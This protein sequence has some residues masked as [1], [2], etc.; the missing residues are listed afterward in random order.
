MQDPHQVRVVTTAGE[1]RLPRRRVL[2]LTAAAA[3]VAGVSAAGGRSTASAAP[4]AGEGF[5]A[6][7]FTDPRPD[8]RPTVLWFWNGTVTTDLVAAQLADLR[9]QGVFEVL[10]FPFD[11]SALRPRFFTEDWFTLIEFTLREAQRHG[12]HLWLFNDDFFPSGRGGGFV[13]NGGKVGD[14]VY[15]P[16]PDLG[17]KGVGRETVVVTGAGPVPLVSRGLSVSDGR[18]LVDASARNGITL[19]RAG[20]DWQ[21][22]AVVAEVRVDRGTAGLV[23]RARDE[24]NG[25]LA[26][27]R[28]DGAVDVWRQVDGAFT[29]VRGGVPVEGFDPAVDH[30]LEVEV[31]GDRIVPSVDGV[32]QPAVVDGTYAT[33]RVGVRAVADQRSSWDGLTVVDAAGRTLFAD[34]FDSPAALDAFALPAAVPPV[35][36]T[37]RPEG[38]A[39]VASVIDLTDLAR[40]AGVWNAPAGRWRVDLFT[41][42]PLGG[43]AGHTYL[44]LLDDEA[45][46]LF[47]DVVPGEYLRRF[48]WAVGGVLRGFADDEPFLASADAHFAAV[49]WSRSLDAELSRSGVTPGIALAA[50]HDE[51]GPDG[52]RLRGVFWR[53]VSDRFASAYHRRQGEWM[54]GHGLRF[55]SNPL[56]DEYGPG[57]QVRSSG[58]LNTTNQW[59]QVPGTDLIFDHFQRGHHRTLS[60]WPASTAHQLGLE[61]VYL[62]AMGGAGWQVT[63]A[64]TREVVGAFAV[65][66]V[67][68]TLLHARFTDSDQ[69]VYPPP[70]Q[71][72]N[73]WWDV[74]APLNDWIGRL[75]EA[76]R[77]PAMA[78][79]ALVQ[80]QRAVETFQDTATLAP[81]DEAFTGAAHALEDVQVDFDFVDEGALDADPALVAHARPSGSALAL[82]K[83][84]YRVVV[85]PWTPVLALGAVS[86]LT[87]FVRGG[88]TLVV[89]GELPTRE[90][91]GRHADLR[92]ALDALFTGPRKAIRA[93]DPMA[94]AAAVVAAGAAAVSLSPPM[95]DVRVL[96]LERGRERAF[97]LMNERDAAVDVTATFPA[98]GVPEVWDPDSGTATTAGVWRSAPFTGEPDGGTAV[99]LRLEPKATLL[100]VFRVGREPAHAVSATAPVE[101]VRVDGGKVR[102]TVRVTAPGPVTVVATAGRRRHRGTVTVTDPLTPV[103]LDG[104]WGF[105]FDREGAGTTRRPL[106]SWTD[107]DSAHS[108]S[109]WYDREFTLDA[110]VF[111]RRRWALDLG[112][113][114]DVAQVEVNGSAVGSRLWAP[115]RVDVT[116]LL[117]P[118]PNLVRVRVTNTGANTRGQVLPSGLVGP[119]LL[120]PERLVDIALAPEG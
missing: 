115:Y 37:A 13:V 14:R 34:G 66:G 83:Q 77:T 15:P 10:V 36:A 24:A 73:P 28:R 23:V 25:I 29:L 67:N 78:R 71:P 40:G 104:D 109:A 96:R 99:V 90:A 94:A 46:D 107:V 72:V 82:G 64:F 101:R 20:A 35:A 50:V 76:C 112:V 5:P 113:V 30:V 3:L 63:P 48:P 86:V 98:T 92:R 22:Y 1:L 120:R 69:I 45:V 97:V 74:S 33:G 60:R 2:A 7:R 9:A 8:S 56:W 19:L 79:T 75:M 81:I 38:A 117:R 118:G 27:L 59:A 47:L 61:R 102:A 55:I 87:R 89:I 49:P 119:V 53:A 26:D 32:A 18:L 65:R 52:L 12:T 17:V 103:P 68:H 57:E 110:A 116:A 91:G 100:V 43:D 85:L 80:P 41:L 106:G 111:A 114:H 58:N 11:T 70:F 39:D 93:A 42:R 62:E 54:A 88:G 16:R 84:R 31:R 105:R 21:D 44:D 108:G 6:A 95:A 4:E 51:L